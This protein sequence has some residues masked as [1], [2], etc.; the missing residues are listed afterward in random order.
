MQTYFGLDE[1]LINLSNHTADELFPLDCQDWEPIENLFGLME[2]VALLSDNEV[3]KGEK[4]LYFCQSRIMNIMLLE[5]FSD[6]FTI[7]TEQMSSPA[8]KIQKTKREIL[9][10]SRK[11]MQKLTQK[12]IRF[13]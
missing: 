10:L 13:W 3:E 4:S 7:K 11:K 5:L 9:Q 1:S 6:T 8:K 2:E 12:R